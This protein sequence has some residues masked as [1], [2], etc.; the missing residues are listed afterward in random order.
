MKRVIGAAVLAVALAGCQT[1]GQKVLQLTPGI[2]PDQVIAMLGQPDQV[3]SVAGCEVYSYQGRRRT[4]HSIRHT[5]YTVVFKDG[6]LVEF[7]P[8]L[9][10][11]DRV[12]DL[13]IAGSAP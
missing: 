6:R 4:R 9:A 13:V 10:R 1:T 3:S 5:T 7:G 12:H 2:G 8:G 11:Q